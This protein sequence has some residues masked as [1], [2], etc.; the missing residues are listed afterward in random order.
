V[1]VKDCFLTRQAAGRDILTRL[2][3]Q[4]TS[5]E[6]S[7]P[8]SWPSQVSRTATTG[9]LVGGGWLAWRA[10]QFHVPASLIDAL[11]PRL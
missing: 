9:A 10:L 1:L 11:L 7:T 5:T 2:S 8:R 6:R 4:I 3:A